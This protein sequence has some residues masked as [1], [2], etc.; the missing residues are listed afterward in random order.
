MAGERASIFGQLIERLEES[1]MSQDCRR[2]FYD[3]MLEILE[4][5]DVK[6]IDNYLN[7]DPSFDEAYCERYPELEEEDE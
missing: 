5:F 1:D 7:I 6:G 2:E 3:I 4:E